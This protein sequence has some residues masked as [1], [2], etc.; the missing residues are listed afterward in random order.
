M[1]NWTTDTSDPE[2]PLYLG[3]PED[4]EACTE[5]TGRRPGHPLGARRPI[6]RQPTRDPVRPGQRPA[7]VPD[8]ATHIGAAPTVHAPTGT[9]VPRGSAR[10]PTA[11]SIGHA[12][13]VGRARDGLCPAG[14]PTRT[15]NVVAIEVPIP[16]T[17]QPSTQGKIFVLAKNKDEVL[18]GRKTPR[19]PGHPRPTRATAMP[20]TLTNEM[21]EPRRSTALQVEH[22]HPPRAVRRAGLRRRHRRLRL[23]ALGPPVQGRGPDADRGRRRTAHDDP[24][25]PAST[26]FPEPGVLGVGIGEGRHIDMQ[27]DHVDRRPKTVTLTE[28]L[29]HDHAA[30]EY[31]GVEFIQYRWYPDVVLDNIFWHDHVD[32]I[33]GWGHGLV[34]QLIVEPK[35][36]TYHDPKTGQR[37]TRARRRHPTPATRWRP[38]CRRQLPR[39]GAVDDQRQHNDGLDAEPARGTV[40]R[41]GAD[42]T[43]AA[44]LSYGNGDPITPL[45]RAYPKDPIVMR[46]INVSPTL[47][48]LH[49]GGH[50]SSTAADRTRRQRRLDPIG[51]D[52]RCTEAS[53]SATRWCSTAAPEASAAARRLPV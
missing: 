41:P 46:T 28:P 35:G 30:G 42:A 16:V 47:D 12:E 32:G 17:T 24:A 4:D 53:A 1:W 11:A 40:D 10:T 29:A 8:A 18:S 7:R 20:I 21:T 5:F 19:T 48:T 9:R 22:A 44:V 31:A 2:R 36:S 27:P 14:A 3:E 37:S 25:R 6:G 45:P 26:K 39:D 43:V 49:L 51:T 33:H 15:F 34:G 50:R 13:P 52:R 23:R 38:A